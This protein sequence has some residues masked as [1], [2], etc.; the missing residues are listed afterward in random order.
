[1]NLITG[2]NIISDGLSAQKAAMELY[3]QNIANQHTTRTE[4]GGAYKAKKPV[5]E[6]YMNASGKPTVHIKNIMEDKTPGIKEYDPQHPHAD[7]SGMVENSNVSTSQEMIAFNQSIQTS[8][9]LLA[10][11][12][13]STR[14][15]SQTLNIGK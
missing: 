1:M 9:A 5:F 11:A 10:I 2:G 8:E 15:A 6:S 3:V 12:N 14:M 7:A 13:Q 4:D